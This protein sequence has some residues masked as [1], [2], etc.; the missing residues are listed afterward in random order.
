MEDNLLENT[1]NNKNLLTRIYFRQ[2]VE[3]AIKIA[4]LKKDDLILDFGCGAGWLEERLRKFYIV[5][6]D[7][8]PKKTFV[9]DYRTI[10]PTK[11][12]CLDVFEHIPLSEIKRIID[13]FKKMGN[14]LQLI[15]SIP[16]GNF[17]SR[18]V[19]K[20]VGKTEIP[21]EHITSYKEILKVLKENFELK[22]KI[23]FFTVTK[24][25]LFEYNQN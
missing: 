7:I 21:K 20:M 11:I 12:F 1:Y 25:F 5:G 24:I 18:K 16:T 3:S 10:K 22:K 17:I 8:N 15:V 23:N 13:N 14:H 2:K 9:K 6:Y 4:H 19:R